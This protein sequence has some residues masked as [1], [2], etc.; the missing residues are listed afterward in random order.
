MLAAAMN[1]CACGYY[2][3]RS[4]CH[5]T[6]KQVH[7]YLDKIS[8]PF[9]ERMD[10]CV[11]TEPVKYVQ[12]TSGEKAEHSKE[13]RKRVEK[14]RAIQ[15]ERYRKEAVSCNGELTPQLLETYIHLGK[16]E[17]SCMERLFQQMALSAR[18]YHKTIKVART[19]ADLEGSEDITEVHLSEAVY[20]RSIDGKF[21]NTGREK[22]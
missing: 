6:Q 22:I 14:A 21:W 11:E 1:P 15:K 19:I 13:I 12:L 7:K 9:L 8:R 16:K 4:I 17:R 10:I 2:P 5:C 3:D 20:Y 18:T